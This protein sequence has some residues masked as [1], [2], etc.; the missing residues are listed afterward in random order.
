[1]LEFLLKGISEQTIVQVF[2][3]DMLIFKKQSNIDSLKISYRLTLPFRLNSFAW[4]ALYWVECCEKY[5][6]FNCLLVL[7]SSE[8]FWNRRDRSV[9]KGYTMWIWIKLPFNENRMKISI[10][11][12]L[13][14][15]PEITWNY[16]NINF[17]Y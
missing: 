11:N 7:T 3:K 6:Y 12:Q 5:I 10:K 1:M 16:A 14:I 4:K 8:L 9:R 13:S 15:Y 2:F 17:H